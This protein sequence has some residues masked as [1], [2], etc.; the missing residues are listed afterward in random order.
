MRHGTAWTSVA[1][2]AMASAAC[3][4]ARPAPM[5]GGYPARDR[6]ALV[7]LFPVGSQCKVVAG[8]ETHIGFPG[9]KVIWRVVNLCGRTA[10]LE[11]HIYKRVPESAPDPFVDGGEFAPR[12]EAGFG[13]E[14]MFERTVKKAGDFGKGEQ[15]YFYWIGVKGDADSRMEPELDIWP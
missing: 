9:R 10:Q 3:A 1:L 7:L 12:A 2:L 11:F 5:S 6:H 15:Q 4:H 13:K 8:P 14:N